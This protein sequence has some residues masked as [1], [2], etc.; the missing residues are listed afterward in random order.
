M[1]KTLKRPATKQS[2]L[3]SLPCRDAIRLLAWLNKGLSN[4]KLPESLHCAVIFCWKLWQ[5]LG[6]CGLEMKKKM[7]TIIALISNL[8]MKTD[9]ST[10][11]DEVSK[12]N[13]KGLMN[14]FLNAT[15]LP[16]QWT[17]HQKLI[18]YILID[19]HSILYTQWS[20]ICNLVHKISWLDNFL[21]NVFF[22]L[23]FCTL[24]IS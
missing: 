24:S 8:G 1:G 4:R 16:T 7:Q 22:N 18:S 2:L 23:I 15:T 13:W 6:S 9:D 12:W 14:F 19:Y 5:D 11:E 17:Y 20:D 3:L 10:F 21:T